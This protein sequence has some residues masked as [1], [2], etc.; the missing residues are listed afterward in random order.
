M[1]S[2]IRQI[3]DIVTLL[4]EQ[5]ALTREI[6]LA[7]THQPAQT[8]PSAISEATQRA[9][10]LT[11]R[12]RQMPPRQFTDKDVT[13]VTAAMREQRAIKEWEQTNRPW[14][15]QDLPPEIQPLAIHLMEAAEDAKAAE[16]LPTST[17][18]TAAPD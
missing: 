4:Q 17:A 12:P 2:W 14:R 9:T 10:R 18:S 16:N 13:V 11:P 3:R 6:I 8:T 1:W 7:L 15:I 5:N